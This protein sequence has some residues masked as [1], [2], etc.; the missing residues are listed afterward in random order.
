MTLEYWVAKLPDDEFSPLYL[1][2]STSLSTLTMVYAEGLLIGQWYKFYQIDEDKTAKKIEEEREIAEQ[3]GE[4][5]D[6][7]DIEPEYVF[8]E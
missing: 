3:N 1:Y 7:E 5:F 8:F 4:E 6:S 2:F